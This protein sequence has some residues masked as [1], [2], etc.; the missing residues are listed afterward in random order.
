MNG[1]YNYK[2]V[3]AHGHPRADYLGHVL[4]HV[5][6]AERALG[7]PLPAGAEVH[8]VDGSGGNNARGNLVICQDKAYHK[9]LHFRERIVRIGGDPDTQKICSTCKNLKPIADFNRSKRNIASGL[10]TQCRECSSLYTRTYVR[11][12]KRGAA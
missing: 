12:S 8:H 4:E 9:L 11:P 2:R 6:V 7:K 10:Q 3:I 1:R 5:L